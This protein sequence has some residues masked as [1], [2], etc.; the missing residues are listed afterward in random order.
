[1]ACSCLIRLSSHESHKLKKGAK[2][3]NIMIDRKARL[4][5]G[6]TIHHKSLTK[7]L[8]DIEPDL[9][10]WL[11]RCSVKSTSSTS[12]SSSSVSS[13]S[14]R[15]L[16]EFDESVRKRIVRGS[17]EDGNNIDCVAVAPCHHSA[18]SN[19]CVLACA[20]SGVV[21]CMRSDDDNVVDND[22]SADKESSD[23]SVTQT[24]SS[25]VNAV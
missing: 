8:K 24:F 10:T 11:L 25:K 2:G 3:M 16:L 13:T 17:P 7:P 19:S 4:E 15:Q 18:S 23:D 20:S 1:M 21:F 5:D 22:G 14:C 6:V 12:S 9:V